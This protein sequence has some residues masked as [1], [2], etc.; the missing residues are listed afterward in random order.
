MIKRN[1][2]LIKFKSFGFGVICYGAIV[3]KY[4]IS[5]KITPDDTAMSIID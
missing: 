3:G 4:N 2:E 5:E 1:W